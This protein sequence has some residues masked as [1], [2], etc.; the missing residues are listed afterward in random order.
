[1][2]LENRRERRQDPTD[3]SH[4]VTPVRCSDDPEGEPRMTK[5]GP[6][7]EYREL[8]RGK[9]SPEEYVEKM[10]RDVDRRLV[11]RPPARRLKTRRAAAG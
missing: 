8:L 1:M 7:P 3:A 6:S 9:I 11:E 2:R 4:T 5:P 10:K